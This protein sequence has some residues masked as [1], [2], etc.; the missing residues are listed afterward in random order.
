MPFERFLRPPRIPPGTREPMLSIWQ[1]GQIG[2]NKNLVE[3]LRLR[4]A[5][6]A[7]LFFDVE[8]SRLG[9]RFTSDEDEPGILALVPTR[10]QGLFISAISFFHYHEIPYHETQNYHV[11]Y[12]TSE[13]LYVVDLTRPL[14]RTKRVRQS[15][16]DAVPQFP[17]RRKRGCPPKR[18]QTVGK[19]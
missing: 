17:L 9:L 4:T 14:A 6:F 16:L 7:I 5:R 10:C 2:L 8:T 15:P 1:R 11:T 18:V 3:S 12:N 13:D 19:G